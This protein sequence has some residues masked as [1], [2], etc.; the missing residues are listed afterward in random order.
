MTDAD[1]D[2][3]IREYERVVCYYTL[4]K[5]ISPVTIGLIAAYLLCVLESAAALAYGT[6]IQDRTWTLAGLYS[7]M[8]IL[9]F[10]M[11]AF[12]IRAWLTDWRIRM[13][14]AVA[15]N[16]PDPTGE[17]DVP[18]P[19]EKHLL[20]SRPFRPVEDIFDCVD[21]SG[22]IS[23]YVEIKRPNAH[24][25]IK[26]AQDATLLDVRA[27]HGPG[28]LRVYAGKEHRAS[29]ERRMTLRGMMARVDLVGPES[30]YYLIRSGC[31]Y[32][33]GRMAGRI[34]RLRRRIYLDVEQAHMNDGLLAYL[35]TVR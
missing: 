34:Y 30:R 28:Q 35:A 22:A 2:H 17:E 8:G 33:S 9:V 14:L 10:G 29:I 5:M 12:T 13:A 7:L 26:D 3:L 32:D 18:D 25:R 4:P 19:F 15:R 21:R 23:Y 1:K 6:Y 20:L 27:V 16:A 11:V 24:W 31:I